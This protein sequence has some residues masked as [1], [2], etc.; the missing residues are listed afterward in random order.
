[1]ADITATC[2]GV[3]IRVLWRDPSLSRFYAY[4]RVHPIEGQSNKHAPGQ[5]GRQSRRDR[6]GTHQPDNREIEREQARKRERKIQEKLVEREEKEREEMGVIEGLSKGGAGGSRRGG[7]E[8]TKPRSHE[9]S[10]TKPR[11][12]VKVP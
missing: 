5:E 9:R 4:G 11:A 2:V 1:M 3:G 6:V 12:S 7:V 10:Q 8:A